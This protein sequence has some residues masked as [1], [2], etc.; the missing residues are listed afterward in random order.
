M[1]MVLEPII[2]LCNRILSWRHCVLFENLNSKT[3]TP[4]FILYKSEI[5]IILVEINLHRGIYLR[6]FR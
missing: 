1:I 2:S 6:I 5:G 4:D 3:C